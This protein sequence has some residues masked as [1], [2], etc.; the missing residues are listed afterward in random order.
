MG[1]F[2]E[3]VETVEDLAKKLQNEN[4]TSEEY[5]DLQAQFQ[6]RGYHRIANISITHSLTV[7]T[8]KPDKSINLSVQFSYYLKQTVMF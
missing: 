6:V 8:I 3:F 4:L 7:I 5:K 1:G 2:S